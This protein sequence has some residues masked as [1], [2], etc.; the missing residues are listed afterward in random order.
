MFGPTPFPSR[1]SGK[2][3][4]LF[5]STTRRDRLSLD[6]S[7]NILAPGITP[8]GPSVTID[9]LFMYAGLLSHVCFPRLRSWSQRNNALPL[10]QSQQMFYNPLSMG[11]HNKWSQIKRQKGAADAAKSNLWGK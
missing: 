3:V 6:R 8:P 5:P 11:G 1:R 4:A 2:S 7:V 9:T 10:P